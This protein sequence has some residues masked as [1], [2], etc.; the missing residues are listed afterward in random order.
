MVPMQA[1][2]KKNMLCWVDLIIRWDKGWDKGGEKK[3]KENREDNGQ[4][5]KNSISLIYAW[6][7]PYPLLPSFPTSKW[8][9][10]ADTHLHNSISKN[11]SAL[12]K[13]AFIACSKIFCPEHETH[14]LWSETSSLYDLIIFF[15]S[16]VYLCW[17]K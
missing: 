12:E 7:Q 4:K 2:L 8:I 6:S 17:E 14:V 9:L 10:Q 15:L 16:P 5:R 3:R 13:I 1:F 11:Y